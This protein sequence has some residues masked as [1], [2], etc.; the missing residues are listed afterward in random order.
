MKK[1]KLC[2]QM[3]ILYLEPPK[4]HEKKSVRNNN[5]AVIRYKNKCTEISCISIHE[6]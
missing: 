6:Q 4:N 1:I 2:L 3:T 5:S